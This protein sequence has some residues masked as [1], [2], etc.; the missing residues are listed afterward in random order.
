MTC[1]IQREEESNRKVRQERRREHSREVRR[2]R[3]RNRELR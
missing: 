1:P 3:E 2:K